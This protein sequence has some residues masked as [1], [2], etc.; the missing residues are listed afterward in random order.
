VSAGDE[1]WLDLADANTQA[2]T[3]PGRQP[4]IAGI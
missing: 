4:L 1:D 2:C 3:A